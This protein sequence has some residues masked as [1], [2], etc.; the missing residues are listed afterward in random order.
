MSD[1]FNIPNA[2]QQVEKA[3]WRMQKDYD[4]FYGYADGDHNVTSASRAIYETSLN[5][6]R[7]L[8]TVIVERLTR[9]NPKVLE[10][11]YVLYL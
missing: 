8:C 10:D 5:N 2:L 7:D 3:Y 6:Y 11:M 4:R 9:E 1:T